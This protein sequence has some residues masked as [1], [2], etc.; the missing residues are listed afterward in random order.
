MFDRLFDALWSTIGWFQCAT[1]VEQFEQGVLLRFG[2][3]KRSLAPGLNWHLPFGIDEIYT[4]NVKPTALELAEQSL[5][6]WDDKRIVCRAVLMWSVFDIHKVLLEVEDAESTL[7]D[8]ALGYVQEMVEDTQWEDI[9]TKDF[10]TRLKKRIQTQA[11][12]WGI[13]VSSVKFQ[14]LAEARSLRLFN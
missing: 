8:I 12:K 14:D 10:R 7:G 9:R 2:K 6:T 13:T 5:T 11:R 1:V 4:V 3:F